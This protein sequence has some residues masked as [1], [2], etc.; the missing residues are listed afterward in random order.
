MKMVSDKLPDKDNPSRI[1][2]TSW[3]FKREDGVRF[4][5]EADS[6]ELI[7]QFQE[8]LAECGLFEEVEPGRVSASK[9]RQRFDI[10]CRFEKEES[11]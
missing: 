3:N 8:A 1:E 7:Y 10:E 6:A 4:T 11:E 9:G 5:G 2:L